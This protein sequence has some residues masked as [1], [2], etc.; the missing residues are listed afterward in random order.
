MEPSMPK[1]F[2][3]WLAPAVVILLAL[4]LTL[5]WVH[6]SQLQRQHADLMDLR[7]DIQN[8]ADSIDQGTVQDGEDTNPADS[9]LAPARL[10][11]RHGGSRFQ[12]VVRI[13]DSSQSQE[14]EQGRKDLEDSRASAKKA[15]AEAR[16]ARSKLSIEE[17]ARKADEKAKVEVAENTWLKWVWIGLGA[18]VLGFVVRSWLR[19][20]N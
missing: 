9:G 5:S 2:P 13:Q 3:S 16:E 10:R 1:R 8:L 19:G 18:C 6:G 7:D 11:R 15:V 17:N 20:R 14:D 12:R 4:Q